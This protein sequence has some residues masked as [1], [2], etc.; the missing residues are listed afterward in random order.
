[1]NLL[2]VIKSFKTGDYTVTRRL[3]TAAIKGIAQPPTL[4][5]FIIEACVQPAMGRMLQRLPE[6][7]RQ[8]EIKVVFCKEELLTNSNTQLSDLVTINGKD[9][10]VSNVKP[11]DE[12][13]NYFEILTVKVG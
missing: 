5:N 7:V 11:F 12:L 3:Q 6:G 1:M 10:E 8:S 13:G 4:S 9:F 2:S